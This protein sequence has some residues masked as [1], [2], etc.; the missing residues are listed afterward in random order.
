MAAKKATKSK[1][2][3]KRATTTTPTAKAAT[4]KAPTKAKAKTAKAATAEASAPPRPS[5]TRLRFRVESNLP[6]GDGQTRAVVLLAVPHG[7]DENTAFFA[8]TPSGRIELPLVTHEGG[9]QLVKGQDYIVEFK[10]AN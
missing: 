3:A 6:S 1:G 2:T 7:S 8:R 4:R 9:N 5:R 10:Q